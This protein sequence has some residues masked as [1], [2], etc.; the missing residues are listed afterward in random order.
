MVLQS[1]IHFDMC[2][3]AGAITVPC[4]CEFFERQFQSF[5]A[6]AD[7]PQLGSQDVR[8]RLST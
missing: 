3:E 5:V 2:G 4:E 7:G 6:D 8:F 1:S